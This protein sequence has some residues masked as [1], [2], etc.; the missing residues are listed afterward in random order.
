[1]RTSLMIGAAAVAMSVAASAEAA[2]P[3]GYKAKADALLAQSFAADGPGASVVVSEHGK[4]VYVGTRGMADVAAKRPITPETVFRMGSI[5]KQFAS[6][7]VL[8]LAAEGKLKLTDP[9]SKF[10]PDYP[11]GEGITVAELLNHTSGIQS[12]TDIPGWMTEEHYG[13]AYTEEQMLA[14]FKDLPAKSK[15]GA[16]WSYNNSGYFLVGVLIEKVTGKPWFDAVDERIAKPLGLATIRY[17]V[18]ESN[19]ATMAHGYSEDEKGVVPAKRIHMSV[20]GAAGAL[21]GTPTDLA[22]W[23]YA[24]HHGKVVTAPYYAQMIAPTHMPDG[25]TAPYGYGLQPG[26]LQGAPT[27]GH[28]GGIPGFST[29]SLYIAKNDVFVAVY[30]N[31]DQ[32]KTTPDSITRRLAAMA[33]GKPFPVF[34]AVPFNRAAM[35]PLMGVYKFTEGQRTF[36]ARDGKFFTRRGTGAESEVYSAGGNRFFYGPNELIWFSIDRGPDGKPRFQRHPNGDDVIETGVWTGPVPA[37]AAAIVVPRDT[38]S[39]YVAGYTTP[40][41]KAVVALG[42]AGLTIQLAG[43]PAFPLRA[44]AMDTFTID[45]VGAK[46]RFVS[47]GGKVSGLEIEQGGKTLPGTRD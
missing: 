37:E 45:Q 10:L 22:T 35:K 16:D 9:L 41:G 32:P 25:T 47:T 39:L 11:G 34:K 13:H 15:P 27:V 21:V 24:L 19:I 26:T 7:V 43:Q 44:I 20:P 12:Y 4:I 14:V 8:Q 18:E 2:L 29:D 38:L 40:I 28:S 31:S 23:G 33:M 30:T 5:T 3:A 6:A 46:I 42:E 36:F 17:G 1:M